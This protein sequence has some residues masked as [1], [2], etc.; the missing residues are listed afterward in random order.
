MAHL[1]TLE[2]ADSASTV[3]A[4]AML[5][6]KAALETKLAG[7]E[8]RIKGIA[9]HLGANVD[10]YYLGLDREEA[11]DEAEAGRRKQ[12]WMR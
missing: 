6:Q 4:E 10:D 12:K 11:E 7:L 1:Q 3:A 9:D 2:G 8:E 5:E